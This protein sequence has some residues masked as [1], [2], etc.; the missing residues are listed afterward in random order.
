[1]VIAVMMAVIVMVA[2]IVMT[3]VPMAVGGIAVYVPAP[4]RAVATEIKPVGIVRA[5]RPI[6][7]V[8]VPVPVVVAPGSSAQRRNGGQAQKKRCESHDNLLFKQ[9][10]LSARY[11]P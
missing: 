2:V 11:H 6:V 4:I 3:V 9:S 5:G 1:M 8:G 7:A 10:A